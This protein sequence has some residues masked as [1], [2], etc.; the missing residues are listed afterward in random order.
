VKREDRDLGMDRP[1]SRRD[2]LHGVGAV[3]AATWVPGRAFADQVLAVGAGA[4]DPPALTGLR[5]NHPGSFEVAH[6]LALGGRTDWGTVRE[7][8]SEVYDLVVVGGGV[9]GLAA[10]Y[11]FREQKPDA[12][13][14]ILDNHDDFGGHAKRN[15]F[16]SG[17][18][19]LIGYGGSQSMETP[20][21]YS[22]TATGLLR[23]LG[24]YTDRFESNY[25][26][27]FYR[28][29]GLGGGV[30]F[31]RENWGVDRVI[32]Y[33]IVR[34]SDYMP[35]APSSI[36]PEAAVAQ[37][38]LSDPAKKELLRLL[39]TEENRIPDVPASE[40]LA[41][42]RSI[43]YR[44]FLTRHVG[45]RESE[46]FAVLQDLSTDSG[47]GI[48]AASAL[49]ALGYTGL[50]GLAAAGLD[51]D[52]GQRGDPY[53][54]HFP[55]GNA[56]VARMLVRSLIPRVAAGSTMEDVVTARFDYAK[57]D[58]ANSNVRLRLQSTAVRVANDGAPAI[59]KRVGITYV[60]AGRAERVW[61]R[62]CV[63]ACY[64]AIIPHLCPE[65]PEPQR[66]AL[67]YAEK[68]PILYTNVLLRNW[69]AWK[70]LKIGAV[71]A[72][73]SYHAVSILDFP[74]S[75]GKYAFSKGPEDPIVVHMERFPHRSNSGLT[76]REQFRAGRHELLSTSF[77][78]IERSIRR[79]LAGT[80]TD[81]GFD[82]AREIEAITVNRWA[83]GYA[84]WYSPLF[85]P[86]FEDDEY[87]HV[88]GRKRLGRIA[89]ANSDAG[90]HATIDSA[91][92]QAHRAIEELAG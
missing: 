53:I 55:D 81:G 47:V 18:R 20:S 21:E 88:L 85:D 77:E 28:R 33:E 82:P 86:E 87:P 19:T 71:A 67:G 31:D 39:V 79:Q 10:A 75:V 7:P 69:H 84:Y 70:K 5:G 78:T 90:A 38:P 45:I 26:Q 46:V 1:I 54:H 4:I 3:A 25:D 65:L 43:S 63:L 60:H 80:L 11:F 44:E 24:V 59:A 42:L 61:A 16:R 62:S 56:S 74:V 27:E 14:L 52:F 64:N 29:N 40:R 23:K 76:T 2:F 66:E 48:E 9:S 34:F 15:E 32:P 35:I 41:Y 13:I 50:P 37:M 8:D 51:R 91:I 57:L 17:D 6:E 58:E 30:Y 83:H 72:P 22:A 89:I 73:G 92:D 49:G 36:S 12:R 68:T